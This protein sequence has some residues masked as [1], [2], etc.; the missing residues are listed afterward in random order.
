MVVLSFARNMFYHVLLS[1]AEGS[2]EYPINDNVKLRLGGLFACV[3]LVCVREFAVLATYSSK[4][5]TS[6]I[7]L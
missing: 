2:C 6:A 3:K 5:D 7:L 1:S 4:P